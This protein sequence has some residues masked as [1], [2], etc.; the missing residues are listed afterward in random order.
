MEIYEEYNN[1]I[2]QYLNCDVDEIN[3]VS[4]TSN[5][6]F[7]ANTKQYGIVYVK[8]YLNKSSHI[9]NEMKLYN[10]I[11]TKYLKEIIISSEKPKFTIFKE[12]KGKTID[13][14]NLDE[15][16][17]YKEKI[18]N[19]VIYFYETISKY[20]TNGYGLLDENLN[21]T[22]MTFKDYIIQRQ[23]DTQNELNDYPILYNLF[24]KI[25]EKY[26]HLFV[27]DNSLVPIDT[28][29]KNI[30]LTEDKEIKFIDP[31]ELI[32]GPLLMGYGDFVAHTYKTSLY[33]CL[34]KKLKLSEEDEKRLRI[35]AIFSSLNILAFLK[36]L[37]V[38]DLD[39]VVPYGNTYT[40]FEL[41]IDHLKKLD[42]E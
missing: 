28:N 42:I 34:L 23:T 40:F 15:I 5:I 36:K 26:S 4:N 41:I 2:K 21:G 11:D 6:V 17:Y 30:M 32:S 1:I 37:G 9:D 24:T 35:Y 14:L 31:G 10:I 16:E 25:Y 27:A 19:S 20:K 22:M 7:K 38:S 33:D 3:L 39:K 13:E 8:F 29:L 18:I 12:L